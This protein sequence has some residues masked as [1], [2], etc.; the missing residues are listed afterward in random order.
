M[1]LP[2][3][4]ANVV[5]CVADVVG[6]PGTSAWKLNTQTPGL[7]WCRRCSRPSSSPLCRI[8]CM[9]EGLEPLG[10]VGLQRISIHPCFNDLEHTII[11]NELRAKHGNIQHLEKLSLQCRFSPN[12]GELFTTEF[13]RPVFPENE[14]N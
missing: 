10:T 12:F 4:Q 9:L 6:Y 7:I 13:F 14:S 8:C 5:K 2:S 11:H 3:L 1:L